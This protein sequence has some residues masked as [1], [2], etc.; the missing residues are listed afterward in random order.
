M[1]VWRQCPHHG[2]RVSGQCPACSDQPQPDQAREGLRWQD[3]GC[4]LL[5]LLLCKTRTRPPCYSHF[6]NQNKFA[7]SNPLGHVRPRHTC[8]FTA[9]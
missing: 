9:T 4:D 2:P 6:A 7:A 3:A 8:G 5:L 1:V